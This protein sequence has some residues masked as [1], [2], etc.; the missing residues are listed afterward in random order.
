MENMKKK[1]QSLM[2]L[3][4]NNL[5]AGPCSSFPLTCADIILKLLKNDQILKNDKIISGRQRCELI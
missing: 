3:N 2:F 4:E 5:S 1:T